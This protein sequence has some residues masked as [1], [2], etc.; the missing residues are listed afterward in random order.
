MAE[1]KIN[2]VLRIVADKMNGLKF[3]LATKKTKAIV[4]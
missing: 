2:N 1:E 4:F 3:S